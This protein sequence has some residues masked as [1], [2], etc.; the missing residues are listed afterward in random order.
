MTWYGGGAPQQPNPAIPNRVNTGGLLGRLGDRAEQRPQ[1]RFGIAVSGVGVL[2]VLV[3]VLVWAGERAGRSNDFGE[4]DP[5]KSV[6]IILSLAVAGAG[7]FLLLRFRSGPLATAGV[8]ASA[9]AVPVLIG[10]ASFDPSLTS[11]SYDAYPFSVDAIALLS[12]GAWLVTYFAVPVARGR[13]FYLAASTFFVWLYLLEKVEEGAIPYILLLPF[14][15]FLFGPFLSAEPDFGTDVGTDV[16]DTSFAPAGPDLSTIGGISLVIGLAYYAAAILLDRADFRGIATPFGAAGFVATVLGIAHLGEDLEGVGTGV[17]FVV[18]GAVLAI[19]GATQ[20]R[21][22]T[23]WAWALGVGVGVVL[24]LGDILEDSAAGFGVAAIVVGIGVIVL[25]EVL[26]NWLNEPDELTSGPSSFTPP[27][28]PGPPVGATA[29]SG[30]PTGQA[31]MPAPPPPPPPPPP[32]AGGS[33]HPPGPP[34]G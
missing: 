1:P 27:S 29:W 17:L 19:Y 18:V 3:G 21:R 8:A 20:G 16:G 31:P 9:L 10:F 6:G 23:T 30:Y 33:A 11:D 24:I 13:T 12:I 28:K 2:V 26:T 5:D 25:A 34:T 32:P 14:G 15:S 7:Y 4:P 22:F